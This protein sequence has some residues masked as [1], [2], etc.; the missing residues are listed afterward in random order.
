M[1]KEYLI[2]ITGTVSG[3]PVT[4]WLTDDGTNTGRRCR[5]SI[6]AAAALFSPASGN[7]TVAAGGSAFNEIPLTVGGGRPFE[8]QIPSFQTARYTAIKNLIDAIA[9]DES[10]TLTVTLTGETG[11]ATATARPHFNPLPYDFGRF[12][13]GWIKGFVLRL[14]TT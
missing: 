8:I 1:A 11:A 10:A 14:I 7:T 9:V 5:S 2:S 4:V 6:P 3:S 13:S 12:V